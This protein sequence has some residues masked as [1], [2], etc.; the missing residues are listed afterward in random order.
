MNTDI[1]PAR[2]IAVFFYG[3]FIRREVMARGGLRPDRV[4][5]ARLSG[6]DIQISPHACI[7]RSDQHSIC[8]ILVRATHEELQRLY[9]MDGVGLFL[10]EA[11]VTQTDAGSVPALCY[12]P[13][14][15]GSQPAD[16]DYLDRLVAAGREHGFP[17]WYLERLERFRGG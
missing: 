5:V 13:P 8:G 4:E 9:S 6:F 1:P 11:V 15:P 14:A 10:P 17:A 16:I 2:R 7:T 3:S 12:I